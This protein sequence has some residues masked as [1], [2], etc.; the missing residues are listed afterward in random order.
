ME[1]KRIYRSLLGIPIWLIIGLSLFIIF[2][3]LYDWF[4]GDRNIPRY[5]ILIASSLILLISIILHTVSLNTIGR[6]AK[7]QMGA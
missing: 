4:V 5:M 3:V 6:M 1:K 7:R 2:S